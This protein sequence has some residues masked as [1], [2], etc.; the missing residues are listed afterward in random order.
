MSSDLSLKLYVAG[1]TPR[2]AQAVEN[3]KRICGE[4]SEP[5]CQIAII[6]VL[7]QPELADEDLIIATP[8]LVKVSPPP[9]RRIIGDL[10]DVWRVRAL[11]G[12]ESQQTTPQSPKEQEV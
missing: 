5:L 10:T 7:E 6:D 4:L 8:T 12:L 2:S 3:L 11:L 9:T 1:R